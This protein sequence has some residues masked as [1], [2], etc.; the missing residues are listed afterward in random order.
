MPY[1]PPKMTPKAASRARAKG[2]AAARTR[3]TLRT[4]GTVVSKG[5]EPLAMPVRTGVSTLASL[6]A[7]TAAGKYAPRSSGP[8]SIPEYKAAVKAEFKEKK[9]PTKS[10]WTEDNPRTRVIKAYA[11]APFEKNRNTKPPT[12]NA[13]AAAKMRANAQAMAKL[14]ATKAKAKASPRKRK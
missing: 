6:A 12:T 8:R 13:Q 9:N 14:R 1:K 5:M 2:Y 10:Q 11:K 4:P 7:K 3:T